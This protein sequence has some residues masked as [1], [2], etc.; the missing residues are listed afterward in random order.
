MVSS[1]AMEYLYLI[2]SFHLFQLLNTSSSM[3]LLGCRLVGVGH[4]NN[5]L[6]VHLVVV[7]RNR[8]VGTI[9]VRLEHQDYGKS[10]LDY[11]IA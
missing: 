3:L 2:S 10:Q 7:H 9:V 6:V 1:H 5:R 11:V 4:C 8:V